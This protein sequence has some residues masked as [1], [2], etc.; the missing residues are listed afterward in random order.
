MGRGSTGIIVHLDIL[1]YSLSMTSNKFKINLNYVCKHFNINKMIFKIYALEQ[2]FSLYLCFTISC[3]VDICM[4]F[5]QFLYFLYILVHMHINR[6]DFILWMNISILY[7]CLFNN[8]WLNFSHG[9]NKIS[10]LCSFFSLSY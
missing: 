7:I 1:F 3:G 6:L 8:F 2:S 5:L 9:E 10:V 4:T